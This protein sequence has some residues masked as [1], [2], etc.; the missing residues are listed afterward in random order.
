MRQQGMRQ[1]KVYNFFESFFFSKKIIKLQRGIRGR[2]Q[3]RRKTM[4]AV[5][6]P[7]ATV[8][9]RRKMWKENDM[10]DENINGW[11]CESCGELNEE[12]LVIYA[13]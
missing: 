1:I 13:S 7:K 9:Q 8:K 6:Y 11:V 10:A 5:K 12:R 4:I 2:K 3:G